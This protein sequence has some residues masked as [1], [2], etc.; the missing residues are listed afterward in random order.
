MDELDWSPQF[1]S[2]FGPYEGVV[3]SVSTEFDSATQTTYL[4]VITSYGV[5]RERLMG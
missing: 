5:V 4:V 3:E 1:K 2:V